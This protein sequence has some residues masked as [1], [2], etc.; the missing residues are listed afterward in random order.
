[1]Q[2]DLTPEYITELGKIWGEA[3][4]TNIPV[5]QRLAG[6]K[7]EDVVRNYRVEEILASLKPEEIERYLRKI[8]KA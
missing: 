7:P 4:L 3:F 2:I 6:L 5:E 1:M 8:T